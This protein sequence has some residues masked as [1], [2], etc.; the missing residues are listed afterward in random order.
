MTV[1]FD[2]QYMPWSYPQRCSREVGVDVMFSVGVLGS[3]SGQL[4][5]I[6]LIVDKQVEDHYKKR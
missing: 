4:A 3:G 2:C 6:A 5:G 1:D